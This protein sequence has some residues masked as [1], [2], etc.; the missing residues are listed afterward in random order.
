MEFESGYL[1][2]LVVIGLSFLC[3]IL[4]MMIDEV[5]RKKGV[6]TFILSIILF[7]LGVYFYYDVGQW[8]K[9]KGGPSANM[10]ND[11]IFVYRPAQVMPESIV[12]FVPP[13]AAPIKK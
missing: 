2:A 3:F 7:C 9:M 12:P 13:P 11:F 10:L 6:T 1:L 4:G 5:N 8:Q